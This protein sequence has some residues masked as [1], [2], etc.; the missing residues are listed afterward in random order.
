MLTDVKLRL[1]L[2][3]P[4][5][6]LFAPRAI[7]SPLD[8]F[9]RAD[10]AV[11]RQDTAGVRQD[12][13]AAQRDTTKL[14]LVAAGS[15]SAEK[16]RDSVRAQDAHPQ[17]SPI[18]RGF[19]IRT[20]DGSAELRIRGSVRLN[21]ILDFKGLQTQS[22]FNTYEIPVGEGSSN[23]PRFQMSGSQTRLGLEAT[24]RAGF[25]D[26]FVKVETDF[27]GLSNTLRLRHAYAS[28]YHF[29]FGQ[30]WSTFA[31]LTAIPLTV[32][33]DGPNGSVSERTVQIRYSNR[34]T[35]G[36]SW[37]VAI[38]SPN[39]E[40]TVSDSV[41]SEPT[42]QSF[43]DLIGRVRTS[44]DWGHIQMSGVVR[45]ISTNALSGN[46]AARV[47]FGILVSGRIYFSGNVPHRLLFQIV[48]GRAVSR[49]IGTLAKKGLDVVYDP[50]NGVTHLVP[51]IG[52]YVSYA[53]QWTPKLLSYVTAGFVR[54]GNLE[55]QPDQAFRFSRYV[56]GN[57][58]WDVAPGT[59]IGAEYS[60][61]LR[62][63]KDGA[64]GTASRFSF[65]LLYDF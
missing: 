20:A 24:R 2:L 50:L 37:D 63:N 38:E 21:G 4:L 62:E 12:S 41:T 9:P 13:S 47:G 32:D 35:E 22:T 29:L 25:G 17:D 43:P 49:Y 48:G 16:A 31:D 60:W 30:T 44:G 36:L 53:R 27:L 61:G 45:S 18:D 10:S 5:V 23:E 40:I 19:L 46:Q 34:L 33:L 39:L 28:L 14:L 54:V 6:T 1:I 58:F 11:V 55:E 8:L 15:D 57:V 51:S 7:A 26:I 42:F 56:S 59:R 52:G 64:H 65:I 3:C